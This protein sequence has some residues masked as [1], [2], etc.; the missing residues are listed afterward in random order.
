MAR[1][2]ACEAGDPI[3]AVERAVLR[4]VKADRVVYER[5]KAKCGWEG[6]T[7]YGV[8]REWGDPRDW[9]PGL[10]MPRVSK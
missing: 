9:K 1:V 6:M 10:W 7:A 2:C 3:C 4:A 5:L 8:L